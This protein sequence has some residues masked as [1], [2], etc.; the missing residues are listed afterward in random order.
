M[1]S[2]IRLENEEGDIVKVKAHEEGGIYVLGGS[3]EATMSITWNY[4]GYYYDFIDAEEGLNWINEKQAKDTINRL[5]YAL[6]R[7]G[8]NPSPD[9]WARTEGNAGH[10][11]AILV[12]WAK[13]YPEATWTID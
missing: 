3:A 12:G 9:Y 13:Q 2:W 1:G 4:F 5:E 10:A 8:D 11:L 7:L 6:K